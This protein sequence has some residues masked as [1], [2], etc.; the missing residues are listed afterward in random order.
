MTYNISEITHN[1]DLKQIINQKL[2]KI[3]MFTEFNSGDVFEC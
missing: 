3:I 2:Y 1:S